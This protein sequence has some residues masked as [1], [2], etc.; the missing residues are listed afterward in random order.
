ML[1]LGGFSLAGLVL[2][3][4]ITPMA[5]AG[6]LKVDQHLSGAEKFNPQAET[7]RFFE[8][9][10]AGQLQ[11][12]VTAEGANRC[13]FKITNTSDDPLNVVMPEAFAAVPVTLAELQ[14][15]EPIMIEDAEPQE[16]E[17]PPPPEGDEPPPPEGDD[18]PPPED[19][20][21]LG[22]GCPYADGSEINTFCF[23]P[24][25]TAHLQL[26]SVCLEHDRAGPSPKHH[27]EVRP[28]HEVTNIK[29]VYE[30]CAMMGRGEVDHQVAQ[31]AA[32]HLNNQ[33]TWRQLWDESQ[34]GPAGIG[35]RNGMTRRQLFDAIEAVEKAV[36]KSWGKVTSLWRSP[37]ENV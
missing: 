4:L 37:G 9:I 28:M 16:G 25:R 32:W 15:D 30:I 22:I 29:G 24:G 10:D 27:Y 34:H 18:L 23:V 35:P 3:L 17:E 6:N 2:A 31:V 21:K 8:G 36:Q 33:I 14:Q 11:V 19:P 26:R 12:R 20:Q 5:M 13:R 7:V 1:R